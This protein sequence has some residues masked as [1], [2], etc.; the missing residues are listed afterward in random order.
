MPN[1]IE[2]PRKRRGSYLPRRKT[3]ADYNIQ[4]NENGCKIWPGR[5]DALGYGRRNLNGKQN[6]VHRVAWIERHGPIPEDMDICHTCDVRMCVETGH[7]FLGTQI[8]N[9]AD[10]D[11]KGRGKRGYRNKLTNADVRF[12][13]AE[14]AAQRATRRSLAAHFHV[15]M[16]TVHAIITG[17]RHRDA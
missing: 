17:K 8:D 6:Y 12:I 1:L 13:R 7:M 3:I 16:E 10:R 15:N 5:P 9:N 2:A 4:P 14:Y 11:R